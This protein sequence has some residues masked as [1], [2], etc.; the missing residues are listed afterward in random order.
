MGRLP[1]ITSDATPPG[2]KQFPDV[3]MTQAAGFHQVCQDLARSC[4]RGGI[5]L[6]LVLLS[7]GC[8]QAQQASFF[9][10]KGRFVFLHQFFNLAKQDLILSF[11]LRNTRHGARNQPAV[12]LFVHRDSSDSHFHS[13]WSCSACVRI[14]EDKHNL[15]LVI[16]PRDQTVFVARNV[17]NSAPLHEVGIG[18]D[19]LDLGERSPVPAPVGET[20]GS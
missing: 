19:L 17:E 20:A 4:L 7:Q 18:I 1:F 12:L 10:R 16:Q 8:Q 2:A 14:A 13:P 6:A 5:G 11:I 9:Q 3:S 15:G